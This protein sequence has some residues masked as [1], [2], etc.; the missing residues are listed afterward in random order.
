M[1]GNESI[2]IKYSLFENELLALLYELLE[3]LCGLL[4]YVSETF[5]SFSFAHF[6]KQRSKSHFFVPEV[7]PWR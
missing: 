5:F 6:N 2:R 4:E 7:T 3:L 1:A